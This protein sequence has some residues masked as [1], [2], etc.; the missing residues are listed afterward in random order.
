MT[1]P[2]RFRRVLLDTGPL[3]AILDQREQDH[4]RCVQMLQRI[5]SPPLTT[6]AVLTEAAWLLRHDPVALRALLQGASQGIYSVMS[7]EN[8]DFAQLDRL[9]AH[10]RDL[11]P[12][13]ADLTLLHLAEREMLDTIFTLDQRDFR[14]FRLPGK[15]SLRLLPDDD[16]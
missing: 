8:E 16:E 2:L 1:D 12:Q 14:A 3:V 5:D 7:I 6:L 11:K 13:L 15:R 9:F 4:T 10:Y